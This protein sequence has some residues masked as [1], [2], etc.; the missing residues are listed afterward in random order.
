[1]GD[2]AGGDAFVIVKH[3]GEVARDVVKHRLL[4]G[5]CDKHALHSHFAENGE[6]IE[7]SLHR[8]HRWQFTEIFGFALIER[9]FFFICGIAP[10][11]ALEQ[12]VDCRCS[13]AAFIEIEFIACTFD[14]EFG[15]E[16]VPCAGVVFHRVIESSVHVDE[17]R[18]RGDAF[19]VMALEK[20]EYFRG[21]GKRRLCHL[22]FFFCLA[23][24]SGVAVTVSGAGISPSLMKYSE[25]A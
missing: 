2:V 21:K 20:A 23:D 15:H 6:H 4:S 18:A 16:P 5:T 7:S 19:V 1:M 22:R 11:L 14:S 17:G 9:C 24:W 8:K 12:G 13:G 10:E 25:S 3:S